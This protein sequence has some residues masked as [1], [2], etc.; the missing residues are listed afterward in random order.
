MIS[1][2]SLIVAVIGRLEDDEEGSAIIS[3]QSSL[4]TAY[5]SVGLDVGI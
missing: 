4:V 3:D 1:G 5:V 2:A